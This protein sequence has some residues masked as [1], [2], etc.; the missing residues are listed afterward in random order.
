MNRPALFVGNVEHVE[1]VAADDH[2]RPEERIKAYG[3]LFLGGMM[4]KIRKALR[5]QGTLEFARHFQV[6]FEGFVLRAKLFREAGEFLGGALLL[7]DVAGNPECSDDFAL[8]RRAAA[9]S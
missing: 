8:A 6:L 2:R 5:H 7:G 3:A 1:K 4:R 9:S